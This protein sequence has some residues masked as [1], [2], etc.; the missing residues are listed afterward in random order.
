[1]R[2]CGKVYHVTKY[3]NT[4]LPHSNT[5]DG[6]TNTFRNSLLLLIFA[7]V[8]TPH[9]SENRFFQKRCACRKLVPPR[10]YWGP[11]FTFV[12]TMSSFSC[13]RCSR[14]AAINELFEWRNTLTKVSN[15]HLSKLSLED[16]HWRLIQDC[17][18]RSRIKIF[19][20]SKMLSTESYNSFGLLGYGIVPMAALHSQDW[21]INSNE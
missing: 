7:W 10:F 18:A 5:V 17:V 21:T 4:W 13:N 20:A 9:T 2:L 8:C 12:W 6:C 19:L 15:G 14:F 16:V 3:L 1:M 11:L